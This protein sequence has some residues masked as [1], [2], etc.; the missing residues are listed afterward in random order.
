MDNQRISS[1]RI[2]KSIQAG[3]I[4]EANQM[5]LYPF[6]IVGTV[7]H[8]E[9][10]GRKLGY[11]TANIDPENECLPSSGIYA[12]KMSIEG[13]IYDAATYIGER[14]TIHSNKPVVIETHLLGEKNINLYTKKVE[15]TFFEKIRDDQNLKNIK[16]IKN[17][18]KIDI[19]N[20]KDTLKKYPKK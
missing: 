16:N 18:I 6:S 13:N 10:I 19:E 12:S 7:V 11:N 5:L 17:Q 20:I 3:K 8:G 15:L 1:S 9:K 14:K 4:K 2:R